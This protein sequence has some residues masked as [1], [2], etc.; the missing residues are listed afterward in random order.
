MNMFAI[1]MNL[2]SFKY[3][4]CVN[5]YNSHFSKR[6][7]SSSHELLLEYE[8]IRVGHEFMVQSRDQM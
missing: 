2:S 1:R 3:V 4:A 8:S 6:E 5:I 7:S